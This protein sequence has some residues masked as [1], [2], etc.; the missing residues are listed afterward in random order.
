MQNSRSI[1]IQEQD[2]EIEYKLLASI[3]ELE[4]KGQITKWIDD[5]DILL[6]EYEGKIKAISNICRHFGG[7]VGYHK[8]KNGTFTC[9]WHNWQFSG[10]DGSCL[11]HP[12]LPLREYELKIVDNEIY[13]NLLG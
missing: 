13:I 11:T 9:L 12:G 1:K 8:M 3:E 6:Y 5:H 10:K 4:Q 2:K 7:P